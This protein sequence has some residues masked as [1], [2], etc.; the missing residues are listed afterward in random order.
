MEGNKPE[1]KFKAGAVTA[2]VWANQGKNNKGEPI[3][4]KTVSIDRVYKDGEDWKHTTSFRTADLPKLSLVTSKA[5]EYL[6]TKS[7]AEQ[8][9]YF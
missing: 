9:E 7:T 2:T 1:H 4:Y 5:Y 8:E 3:G 6:V